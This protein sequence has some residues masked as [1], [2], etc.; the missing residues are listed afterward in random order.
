MDELDWSALNGQCVINYTHQAL[1]YQMKSRHT[2]VL[3]VKSACTRVTGAR[4]TS[5]SKM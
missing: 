3:Q 5:P 1:R 2:N 4:L